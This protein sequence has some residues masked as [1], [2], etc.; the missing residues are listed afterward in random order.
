M[1][2]KVESFTDVAH[3]SYSDLGATLVG[4]CGQYDAR[5]FMNPFLAT[6][7]TERCVLP[8]LQLMC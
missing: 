7:A 8:L 1:G 6:L 2:Q 4:L 3:I 5:K